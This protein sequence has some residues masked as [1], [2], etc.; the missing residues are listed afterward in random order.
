MLTREEWKKRCFPEKPTEAQTSVLLTDGQHRRIVIYGAGYAGLIFLECLRECGLEPECMLDTA[1]GKQG[2][3]IFGVPV[4]APSTERVEGADVVVCLLRFD[5]GYRQIREWMETLGCRSVFHLYE[6]RADQR[7]FRNQPLPI[8]PDAALLHANIE[9]LYRVYDMLGDELSRETLI[10]ILRFLHGDLTAP[11]PALPLD[12]QYFGPY[13]LREDEVFVDCGAH[14]GEI[15]RHFIERSRGRFHAYWAFEPDSENVRALR[16]ACPGEYIGR[17][18]LCH[19]ALGDRCGKVR[20]R[21]Y[22][23]SNSLIRAD[24]E[25]EADCVPLDFFA[26][27]LYPTILKIDVEGWEMRLLAGAREMICR[28]KPVIAVAVYHRELDFWEIPLCLKQWV[29]EYRFYL[30]SYM[31]AAETILYAIPPGRGEKGDMA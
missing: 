29:P 6:L 7:L 20:V 22:D 24:G 28:D 25:Q 14:V 1:P 18:T 26:G 15:F 19:T 11:I 2:R 10:E 13:T 9:P 30:R 5:E 17:F 21:N 27:R 31:N 8:S 23:G 16:D 12:E 4:Y 3:F